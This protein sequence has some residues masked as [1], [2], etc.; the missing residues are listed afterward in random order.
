MSH[1]LVRG[2]LFLSTIILFFQC[3]YGRFVVKPH[4][5]ENL[6]V[7]GHFCFCLFHCNFVI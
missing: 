7:T 1:A 2:M 6:A 4:I 3:V 5:I